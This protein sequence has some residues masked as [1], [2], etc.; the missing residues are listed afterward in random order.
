MRKTYK[1][2][3]LDCANCAMK[4]EQAINKLEGVISASVNFMMQ[5]VTIEADA[6]RFPEILKE[7][8][9]CCSR[10]DRDCHILY[11]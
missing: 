2:E 4:M 7:A 1:M 3:N 9:A 10:V 6:D 5:K 8:D 11:Q